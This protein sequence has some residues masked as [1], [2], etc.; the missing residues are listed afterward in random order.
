MEA[1]KLTD[2]DFNRVAARLGIETAAVKAV[3]KVETGGRGGF[4]EQGK[5]QILFEGHVFWKRL[6][7]RGIDP[8]SWAKGNEDILYEKPT[9]AYYVGG[10][11]EY[12][13]LERAKA[14]DKIAALESAS[15]GMFQVMG[16]NYADC[17]F[18]DVLSFV[19][20][21]CLSEGHQLEAF[22]SFVQKNGMVKYLKAK[23]WAGFASRYNGKGYQKYHYDEKMAK[24][25]E[26]YSATR[27]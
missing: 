16:F 10:I 24:A 5:P 14:I 15:W 11:K 4:W 3:Q 26:E 20:A 22:A 13:R 21:M 6:V 19:E 2:N 23:D 12:D 8:S 1:I 7:Q 18:K 9:S 25:Y 17:G 27:K